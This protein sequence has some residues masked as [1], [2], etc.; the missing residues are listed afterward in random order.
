MGAILSQE[1]NNVSEKPVSYTSKTLNMAELNY[2]Q[3]EKEEL[4]L[5][6]AVKKFH[7]F[8]YGHK[9]TLYTDHKPILGLFSED[10]ELPAVRVLLWAF[11]YQRIITSCC[12]VLVKRMRIPM[13]Y[14]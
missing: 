11:L 10:K 13:A 4:E 8:L 2:T 14:L 1:Q 3:I 5:V 9:F 12:T 7:Q 6:F